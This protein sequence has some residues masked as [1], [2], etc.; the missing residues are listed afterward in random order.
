MQVIVYSA[1]HKPAHLRGMASVSTQRGL[2]FD[3]AM[4]AALSQAPMSNEW[5]G[6]KRLFSRTL[7]TEVPKDLMRRVLIQCANKSDGRLAA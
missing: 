6:V 3:R 4:D 2:G 1:V 5:A 7:G